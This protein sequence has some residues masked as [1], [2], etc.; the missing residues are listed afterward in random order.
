M[1]LNTAILTLF[2]T[3]ATISFSAG[4]RLPNQSA[5]ITAR[6]N[7][8][9]AS[10]DDVSAVYYN[11]A[12]L[13]HSE[14]S[15]VQLGLNTIHFEA[16]VDLSSGTSWESD[17]DLAIVPTLFY[18]EH[19]RDFHVG[20]GVFAPF[21]L[22]NRFDNT[23]PFSL[24]GYES[25]VDY[26]RIPLLISKKLHQ[27]LSVSAGI[28]INYICFKSALVELDQSL[29]ELEG[30]GINFGFVF[31]ILYQP[32]AGHRFGLIYNSKVRHSVEGNNQNNR[33]GSIP[34]S[35][36]INLPEY[37]DIGYAYQPNQRWL[38]ELGLEWLNWETL[39]TVDINYPHTLSDK[40]I[41]Y[42]WNAA[43]IYHLGV[44]HFWKKNTFS[45]GYNYSENSIPDEFFNPTTADANRNGWSG[46]WSFKRNNV[47]F[48]LSYQY[49]FSKR[50][51][52]GSM[53]QLAD[54]DWETNYRAVIFSVDYQ[55]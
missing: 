28:H 38:F 35:T 12:A 15:G 41:P 45:I 21:G 51:V 37:L 34:F 53:Y 36:N 52:K 4:F 16:Q 1:K 48:Q 3:T 50:Q 11:P 29:S 8:G 18:S 27:S 30:D 39:D 22:S 43:L 31:S 40:P 2:V 54:G 33:A 44:A 55:F 9:F 42:H 25:S 19:Y 7:A 47:D 14:I 5:E 20:F 6:G 32:F 49:S 23:V 10:V 17:N 24:L 26:L 46:G 13:A